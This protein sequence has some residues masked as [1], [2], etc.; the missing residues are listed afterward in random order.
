[1]TTQDQKSLWVLDRIL[2]RLRVSKDNAALARDWELWHWYHWGEAEVMRM[3]V[4]VATKLAK[5]G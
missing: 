1:M 3:H 5:G 4:K 2:T